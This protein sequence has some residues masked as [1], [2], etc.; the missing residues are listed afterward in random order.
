VGGR[1]KTG[2]GTV[3]YLEFGGRRFDQSR[4]EFALERKGAFSK[5]YVKG[6]IGGTFLEPF[7]MV[8]DYQHRKIAFVD[9]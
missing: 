4:V 7:V 3:D 9:K 6:N 1:V 8:L 5:P 2:R